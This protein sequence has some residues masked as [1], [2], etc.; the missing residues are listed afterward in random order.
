M[1]QAPP[2]PPNVGDPRTWQWV[3]QLTADDLLV[4]APVSLQLLLRSHE[5]VNRRVETIEMIDAAYVRVQVSVDFRLPL[6]LPSGLS[7]GNSDVHFVPLTWLE[8]RS[9]LAYFD[10]C[11]EDGR[12]LPLLTRQENGTL[13]GLVLVAAA[14]RALNTQKR[15]PGAKLRLERD[16]ISYLSGIPARPRGLAR[17]LLREVLNVR[18]ARLYPD[19]RVAH[20]LF[21]NPDFR[22]LLGVCVSNSAVHVP[23]DREP[24]RRRIIKLSWEQRWRT[25]GSRARRDLPM[26]RRV[27]QRV[28][29]L[30]DWTA[31]SP[32]LE[33]PHV[34]AAESFHVQIAVPPEVVMT[35]VGLLTADPALVPQVLARREPQAPEARRARLRAH[36]LEFAGGFAERRHL[37]VSQAHDHRIGVLAVQMRAAR[38]GFLPGATLT[39][40]L[41]TTILVVYWRNSHDMLG[42]SEVAAAVLLLVP[43]LIAGFLVRPGEHA[44]ARRLLRAPR[45]LT[46]ILA[47]IPLSAAGVLVA[48]TDDDPELPGIVQFF[49]ARP[50]PTADPKL[51]YGWLVLAL[52]AGIIT[53]LLAISWWLPRATD[54]PPTKALD[55][56]NPESAPEA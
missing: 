15:Y 42:Q 6:N 12:S 24:G 56:L 16:L 17:G 21:R 14:R 52:A 44:M 50:D 37:Y 33:H 55:A 38:E 32:W 7:L 30:M 31:Y 47:A 34:G 25:R 28:I 41:V 51:T 9:D 3:G 46:T 36:E 40:A 39:A 2:S 45:I 27:P 26:H 11:D 1:R 18:D 49:A 35:G 5:W 8:R 43:A 22:R 54:E 23:L 19:P 20:V 48:V 13:T 10:V 29:E 53:V 4:A